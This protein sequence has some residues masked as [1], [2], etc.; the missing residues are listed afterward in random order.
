MP[1]RFSSP[2][3]AVSIAALFLAACGGGDGDDGGKREI[4]ATIKGYLAAVADGDG[5]RACGYL[6]EN[7][8]LGIFEFRRVHVGPD[9]PGQAC[10]AIVERNRRPPQTRGVEIS[11]IEIDG[12]EAEASVSGTPVELRKTDGAWKINVFG[13]ATDVRDRR[14]TLQ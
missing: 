12:D 14:A 4:E 8:Q 7:A 3:L 1:R 10:A 5:R 9:H 11:G 2:T 13:L 6:T